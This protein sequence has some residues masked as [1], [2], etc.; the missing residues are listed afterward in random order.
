MK[1]SPIGK[2]KRFDVF[3]RDGFECHYCGA[4]PPA[5]LLH[6]DHIVPVSKGGGNDLDN[7]ITSCQICNIGKG[8][9]LLTVVPQSL[10]SRAADV[11][12]REAQ[13]AAFSEVMEARRTRLEQESWDVL[14]IW[15]DHFS[16]DSVSKSY[17]SSVQ[18]FVDKLGKHECLEAMEI[19]VSRVP[20]QQDRALRYFCGICWN[21]V[22]EIS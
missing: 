2:K 3:K 14:D 22:R 7:L 17:F 9:T 13:I 21:K 1:R 8:A 10:K 12:E 11:A 15:M 19:A 16:K 4:K 20:Y 18:K 6:V 5:V